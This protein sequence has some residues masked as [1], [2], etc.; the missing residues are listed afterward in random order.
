MIARENAPSSTCYRHPWLVTEQRMACPNRRSNAHLLTEQSSQ[1]IQSRHSR[2]TATRAAWSCNKYIYIYIYT[3]F[4]YMYKR[5]IKYF[6]FRGIWTTV[7]GVRVNVRLHALLPS[8][9]QVVV[10]VSIAI[11]SGCMD[12]CMEVRGWFLVST[13]TYDLKHSCPFYNSTSFGYFLFSSINT[14]ITL[15]Q[16]IN[17]S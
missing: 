11:E 3:W 2:H 17:G 8:S 1:L 16:G 7:G 4:T 9:M 6:G 15:F 5:A 13:V 10:I 12:I 14:S